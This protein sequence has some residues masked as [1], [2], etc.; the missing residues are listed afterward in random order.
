MQPCN[1]P[2]TAR[3]SASAEEAAAA[4]DDEDEEEDDDDGD[5]D[6]CAV[7]TLVPK[8]RTWISWRKAALTGPMSSGTASSR[9][10]REEEEVRDSTTS[11]SAWCRLH[12]QFLW[13]PPYRW[14][15]WRHGCHPGQYARLRQRGQ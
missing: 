6:G 4:E 13:H 1:R 3:A 12:P 11:I 5:D 7:L 10:E 8:S 15:R 14:P 2:A 9:I